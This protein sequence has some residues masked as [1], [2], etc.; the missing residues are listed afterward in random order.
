MKK[1]MVIFSLLIGINSIVSAQQES[2]FSLGVNYGNYFKLGTSLKNDYLGSPGVNLGVYRFFYKNIGMFFN[3]GLFF[4]VLQNELNIGPCFRYDF[5]EKLKVHF[6]V[7]LNVNMY[8]LDIG[9]NNRSSADDRIGIGV[10]GDIGLKYDI[11]DVVYIDFGTT[12]AYNFGDYS[13]F[14]IKP[15]IAIGINSYQEKAHM[16]KPKKD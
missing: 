9:N 13:I 7:G 2:W 3:I 5:N 12:L 1:L 4:P 15:Y 8:L 16:G 14:G 11:T 10:G 6:G